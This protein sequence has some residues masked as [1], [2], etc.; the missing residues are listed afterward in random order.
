[1]VDR[2]RSNMMAS[3]RASGTKLEPVVKKAF[4]SAGYRYRLGGNYRKFGRK[5]PS[6]PDAVLP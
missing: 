3:V 6:T 1:M 2:K 4:R 5:S